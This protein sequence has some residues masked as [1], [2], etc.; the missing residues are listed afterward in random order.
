M[1]SNEFP[2][3]VLI[4]DDEEPVRETIALILKAR[5]CTVNIAEDG[6]AGLRLLRKK[7]PDVV[8][9]DVRMPRMSGLEFLSI[10]RRRYPH[11]AT[12]AITGGPISEMV[13]HGSLADVV[14]QKGH[15]RPDH[16]VETVKLLVEDSM[17]RRQRNDTPQ[18]SRMGNNGAILL[19]CIECL[20]SFSLQR[21]PA[22][23]GVH[24]AECPTC[25][26]QIRYQVDSAVL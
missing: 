12:I 22:T 14:M 17:L 19:T 23:A 25:G 3:R 20:R 18:F 4:V 16:L 10:V 9:S 11:I 5:G 1:S 6:L 8:I 24:T 7:Q 2:I 13:S 15:Y 21:A 26:W